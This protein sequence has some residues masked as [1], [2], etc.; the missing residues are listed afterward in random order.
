MDGASVGRKA[1]DGVALLGLWVIAFVVFTAA[2]AGADVE[3]P[4]FNGVAV[5]GPG[6]DGVGAA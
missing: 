4:A 5:V 2:L 6:E 3:P 1:G